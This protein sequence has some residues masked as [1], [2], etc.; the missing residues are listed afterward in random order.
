MNAEEFARKRIRQA[1][2]EKGLSQRDMAML[3]R[4][5]QATVSDLERGRVQLSVDQLE[6][7][8]TILN[9][10]PSFFL[11]S[12][13]GQEMDE[14]EAQLL[15]IVRSLPEEWQK[16]ILA[17]AQRQTILY[18]RVTPFVRAGIPEDL[19]SVMLSEEAFDLDVREQIEDGSFPDGDQIDA[20][21]REYMELLD[22]Y[23]QW[24]K[25]VDQQAK[26]SDD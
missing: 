7:F 19:Y 18:E 8:A 16:R 22:R 12:G 20:G 25:E 2:E 3:L 6:R 15:D 11:P 17:D 10:P 5:T 14:I 23:R 9:K 13:M 26:K 1:R 4:V 21:H 24:K